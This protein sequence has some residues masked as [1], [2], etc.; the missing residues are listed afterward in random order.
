MK[1]HK[2]KGR[3]QS[4]EHIK[5]RSL[6][7]IGKKLSD[8]HRKK[9]S[10]AKLGH[11]INLGK[12]WK[13]SEQG[14]KNHY[15]MP[16][17]TKL[18]PFSKERLHNMSLARIGK[19]TGAESPNWKGGVTPINKLIRKSAT[20]K[21]WR[22]S[23]FERDNY[24]CVWCGLNSGGGKSVILHADHIKPF[25]YF[26]EL[27]FAIDNGRTLCIDCHKTTDTYAGKAL[28]QYNR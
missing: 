21:L 23:I 28:K 6:A 1:D 7:L 27:R 20:Y 18:A 17:G 26:P 19:R 4:L 24:T 13:I 11:K 15:R 9:L 12:T 22:T 5:K 10:V 14:L 3:K 25:A 2:N 8:E 16:K